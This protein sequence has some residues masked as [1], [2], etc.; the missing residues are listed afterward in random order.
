MSGLPP[1]SAQRPPGGRPLAAIWRRLLLG[2]GLVFLVVGVAGL[3]LP[4]VPGTVCLIVAAACFTRSSP[5]FEAWLLDHPRLGPPVRQ[6]RATGAI[7]RPAKALAVTSLGLSW[8]VVLLTDAP[9]LLKTGLLP[10]F[11]AV[12]AYIVTRPEGA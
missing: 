9:E 3:F 7:P 4:L 6:W 10:V 12:A 2:A 11:L 1:N 5:R 8:L